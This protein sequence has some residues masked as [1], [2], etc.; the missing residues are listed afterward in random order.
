MSWNDDEIGPVLWTLAML[1]TSVIA[2]VIALQAN[3]VLA[4]ILWLA[5]A[6]ILLAFRPD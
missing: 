2:V 1:L 3:V 5:L 4:A 6:S